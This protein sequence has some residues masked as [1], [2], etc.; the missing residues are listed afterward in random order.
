MSLL[1]TREVGVR[2]LNGGSRFVQ[3]LVRREPGRRE[4][5]RPTKL[6]LRVKQIC[7]R[8]VDVAGERVDLLLARACKNTVARGARLPELR[9]RQHQR[10]FQLGVGQLGERIALAHA[11]P[12]GNRKARGRS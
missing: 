5:R 10:S 1:R 2:R 8:H 6:L 12:S 9:L 7:A 3:I 4:L 11:L